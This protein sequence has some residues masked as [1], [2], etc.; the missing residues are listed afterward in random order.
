VK[1]VI[2]LLQT[3]ITIKVLNLLLLWFNYVTHNVTQFHIINCCLNA[4]C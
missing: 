2:S 1:L 4:M 3:A